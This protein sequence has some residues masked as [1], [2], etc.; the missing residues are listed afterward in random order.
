MSNALISIFS[1]NGHRTTS[2]HLLPFLMD[3]GFKFSTI[4][5]QEELFDQVD[6]VI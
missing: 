3:L 2:A 6:F 4:T 1:S 5:S